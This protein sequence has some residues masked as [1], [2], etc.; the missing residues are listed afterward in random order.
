ESTEPERRGNGAGFLAAPE[1]MAERF[2][3]HPQAVAE[4]ARLA[5]RLRFDLT[6]DLGYSYPGAEDGSADR[7]LAAACRGRFGERYDGKPERAEAE[8]RL[9]QELG[10]I[11][12]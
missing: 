10:L 4:T 5:E 9:E 8:R 11:A 1:R 3:E 7:R 2:A 6:R 12:K